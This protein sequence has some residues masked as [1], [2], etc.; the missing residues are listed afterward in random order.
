MSVDGSIDEFYFRENLGLG[1]NFGLNLND[2][3]LNLDSTASEV[4]YIVLES[5]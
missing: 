2:P 4:D 3:V 1:F 5:T